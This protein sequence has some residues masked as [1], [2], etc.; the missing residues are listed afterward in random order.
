MA[1]KIVLFSFFEHILT[2]RSNR[3]FWP[4]M[5]IPFSVVSFAHSLTP[6][7]DHQTS[8]GSTCQDC[9]RSFCSNEPLLI[10]FFNGT[11]KM[12]V[13][14]FLSFL[15]TFVASDFSCYVRFHYAKV[16]Y[17]FVFENDCQPYQLDKC[18]PTRT[19]HKDFHCPRYFCVS[20]CVTDQYVQTNASVLFYLKDSWKFFLSQELRSEWRSEIE[21]ERI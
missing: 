10:D 16:C 14:I 1:F 13:A 7:R 17:R 9:Y 8:S 3:F 4:N 12:K 5:S 18:T 6:L 21:I 19:T 11:I 2:I 15:V 20:I